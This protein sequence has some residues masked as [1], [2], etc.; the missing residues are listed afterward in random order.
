[1]AD[2]I[3]SLGV[4]FFAHRLRRLSEALVDNGR[5][6]LPDLG[7]TAPPKAGSTLMLLAAEGPLTVTQ[8][9]A[10]LRLSHPL[11]IKLVRELDRLG[12]AR[13]QQDPNDGRRRPV[14]LTP[15]GRHQ[16][17]RM[18]EVN[19]LLAESY[20]SLFA[21]AG[22]DGMAAVEAIERVLARRELTV[23]DA[24]AAAASQAD[25]NTPKI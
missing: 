17:E 8:I 9:A 19:R 10:R 2:F 15:A 5:R 18:V 20:R 16:A 1:M 7:I 4:A 12:L 11:I 6:S 24:T 23:N 22:F 3:E 25:P 21:E 13:A 14:A